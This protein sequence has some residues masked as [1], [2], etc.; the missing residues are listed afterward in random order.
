MSYF[1]QMIGLTVQNFLS[2]AMAVAVLMAL[3]RGIHRKTTKTI[4]NFWT[5]M[6]RATLILLPLCIILALLLVS[7]GVP[8]TLN[9]PIT[10]HLVQSVTDYSGNLVMTQ[11]IPVGP[12]ASQE[13]I[14]ILGTNGGGFFNTNSAHP[15]ENPTPLSNLMEIIGLLLIP[16]S[17]VL[18]FGNMVK[19]RRQGMR[20]PG[21]HDSDIHGLPRFRNM[22]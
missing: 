6:T 10:G 3:I 14:K 5:D 8:Q 13:A 22:G 21:R 7:Q 17:L 2:A 12:V 9:G 20:D 15:F 4:G 19:D 11:N 16:V 1:T 18:V